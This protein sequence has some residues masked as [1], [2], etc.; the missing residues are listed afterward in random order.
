M[1]LS[2]IIPTYNNR[3]RLEMTLAYMEKQDLNKNIFEVI[4]VND[5][6]NDGTTEYLES[7][8]TNLNLTVIN[9]INMGQAKARNN[10]LARAEGEVVL[11]IDDDVLGDC[12]F[13]RNHYECHL[14]SQE[15][16]L[17][18][19]GRIKNIPFS[20][21]IMAMH[22]IKNEKGALCSS[23]DQFVQKDVYLNIREHIWNSKLDYV[24]WLGFTTANVS[25][26][27]KSIL[28]A[29][30]FDENFIGWGP[31][32]VE[33]GYRLKSNGASF[34]FHSEIVNYHLDKEKAAD[35]FYVNLNKN[36]RYLREK[37]YPGNK[38]IWGYIQFI[39]GQISL[40]A[41]NALCSQDALTYTKKEEDYYFRFVD[42]FLRKV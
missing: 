37:K 13:I 11:F 1:K 23:L 42:Y 19:V 39:G 5:G 25:L 40:E 22:T 34:V 4:L 7:Y 6:S 3:Q 29:G 35:T 14:Q 31:E 8:R 21:Y 17:V 18:V 33:L 27:R 28:D 41:F 20:Q 32:D 24:S 38:E 15:S 9:Q 36:L 30:G 12:D 10:A 16:N 2:I 26:R